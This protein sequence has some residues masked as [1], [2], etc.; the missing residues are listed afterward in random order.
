MAEVTGISWMDCSADG[1]MP[2]ADFTDGAKPLYEMPLCK[3]RRREK[4]EGKKRRKET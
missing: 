4:G 3:E 2:L 1:S